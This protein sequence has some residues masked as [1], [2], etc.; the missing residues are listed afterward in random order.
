[1]NDVQKQGDGVICYRDL[2]DVNCT[3]PSGDLYGN[4]RHYTDD[5]PNRAL[6]NG[7]RP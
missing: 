5:L 3:Y 6:D 4:Q 1:M 7:S 2:P